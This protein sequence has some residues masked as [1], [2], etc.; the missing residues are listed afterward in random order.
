M[1]SRR[2]SRVRRTSMIIAIL[3][4]TLSG[5]SG[6]DEAQQA[7]D[8]TQDL[9]STTKTCLELAEVAVGRIDEVRA[10]LDE[11]AE[12]E[13]IARRTAAEFEAKMAESD[14]PQLK[15][16]LRGYV[17]DMRR[18]A[19]RAEQGQTPDLGD[20]REANGALVDACS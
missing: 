1:N 4:F 10:H 17:A 11:E 8:D 12:L 2:A 9:A 20:L 13:R 7:V 14:D 15:Q 18:V 3:S 5:C 19:D 6:L 16:A